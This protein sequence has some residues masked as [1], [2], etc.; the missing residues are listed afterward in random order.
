MVING[1]TFLSLKSSFQNLS[2][3]PSVEKKVYQRRKLQKLEGIFF[4]TE[5]IVLER[6][7]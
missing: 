5:I 1:N 2:V 4:I 6:T 3:Y 7:V